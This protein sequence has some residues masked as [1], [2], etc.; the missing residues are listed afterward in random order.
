MDILF[1]L[2]LL[3]LSGCLDG[4]VVVFSVIAISYGLSFVISSTAFDVVAKV[5][6]VLF[7]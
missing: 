3:G 7:C 6:F 4:R 5:K 2:V 1:Y